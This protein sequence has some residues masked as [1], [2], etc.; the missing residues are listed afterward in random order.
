MKILNNPNGEYRGSLGGIVF[1]RNKGGA[2]ARAKVTPINR[3]SV[4][5]Q[6]AR[7]R[8]GTAAQGFA[9]LTATQAAQWGTFAKDGY[10]PRK[11]MNV[12]QFSGAN[13]YTAL[14]T[15]ALNGVQN[16]QAGSF[17]QDAAAID[18][19]AVMKNFAIDREAPVAGIKGALVAP[20]D[21]TV[22]YNLSVKSVE[23]T[24]DWKVSAELDMST[25]DTSG[26]VLSSICDESLLPLGFMFTMSTPNPVANRVY[27]Q[28]DTTVL[29]IVQAPTVLTGAIENS[30]LKVAALTAAKTGD[31]SVMPSVGS[32]INIGV[33]LISTNGMLKKLGYG[34]VQITA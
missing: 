33:W 4:A 14:A 7:T 17:N 1:S 18:A 22:S 23:L 11:K 26:K 2:V 9:A 21:V 29:A 12:G 5:Q 15:T 6:K 16:G 19:T 27:R 31:W 30:V 25:S 20:S 10:N 3:N 8:T 24:T 34:E 13:A 32:W 28:N